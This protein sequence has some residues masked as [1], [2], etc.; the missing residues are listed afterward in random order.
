MT[1]P[2]ITS[3]CSS[4]LVLLLAWAQWRAWNFASFLRTPLMHRPEMAG[5]TPT[6]LLMLLLAELLGAPTIW[7]HVCALV[8]VVARV[9]HIRALVRNLGKWSGPSMPALGATWVVI[10]LLALTNAFLVLVSL[11]ASEKRFTSF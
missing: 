8:L 5:D 9:V 1:V 11:T 10:L 6:A 7:L 4:V 3:L 2:V